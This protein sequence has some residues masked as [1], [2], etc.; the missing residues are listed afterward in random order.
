MPGVSRSSS[1]SF[2]LWVPFKGLSG[3][4]DFKH[5][6][7]NYNKAKGKPNPQKYGQRF[8]IY[9]NLLCTSQPK[10]KKYI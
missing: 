5:T 10:E 1:A 3:D 7:Q 8:S 6:T 9:C 2:A 4:T